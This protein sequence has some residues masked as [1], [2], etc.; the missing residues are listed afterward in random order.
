MD[1]WM[2]ECVRCFV[3]HT[4]TNNFGFPLTGGIN[5]IVISVEDE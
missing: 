5:E 4:C 1:G 2:D 3:C